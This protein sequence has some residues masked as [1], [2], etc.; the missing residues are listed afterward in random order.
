MSIPDG[1][2]A[3]IT[4]PRSTTRSRVGRAPYSTSLRGSAI[5]RRV[6]AVEHASGAEK[7]LPRAHRR[8]ELRKG[9]DPTDPVDDGF[10]L[11]GHLQVMTPPA[12]RHVWAFGL[13]DVRPT[14]NDRSPRSSRMSP[15]SAPTKDDGGTRDPDQDL[16]GPD[17]VKGN[18]LR[19]D[20]NRDVHGHMVA[21]RPKGSNDAAPTITAIH[22]VGCGSSGRRGTGRRDG[23]LTPRI[24][25]WRGPCGGRCDG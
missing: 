3:V 14:G 23:A 19:E 18:E 9:V 5:A 13:V 1:A 24:V 15:R 8:R 12:R 10:A 17:G 21:Q 22:S 20:G 4:F 6:E 25:R 11:A 7:Q 2:A 16:V